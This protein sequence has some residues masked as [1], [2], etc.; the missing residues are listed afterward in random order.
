MLNIIEKKK[1]GMAL[2]KEE[3]EYVVDGATNNTI[4]DYQLS[5]L[6]MAIYFNG[7]DIT[8]TTY[9]TLAMANSGDR[10]DLSFIDGIKVDKHSTG[11][12]GDSTT[13]IVAPLVVACGGIV[14]KM[15]GR[16][17]G[18]TGGTLD[19][20]MSIPN[21]RI[22]FSSDEFEKLVLKNRLAVV[23][24]S[25]NLAPADKTLYALRD[26]TATVDNIS[27]IS[28]SIMSKKIAG[29]CDAL[30][31]DVKYGSGSLV[32]SYENA[33]ELADIMIG[34]GKGADVETRAVLSDM[35][36]PLGRYIGNALEVLEVVETLKG[37]H[38]DSRLLEVC[39]ELGS[40]MLEL[41][42][43]V[44]DTEQGKELMKK[45]IEDGS[46]LQKLKDMIEAQGGDSSV[47][48]NPEKL[49]T[50]KK[51]IDVT[52][53]KAGKITA[54]DTKGIGRSAMLLGAGREKKE[55]VIDSAVGLIMECELGD[56]IK[57]GDVICKMH[58]NDETNEKKAIKL[59]KESIILE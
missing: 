16:G 44:K 52:S 53:D 49:P 2:T 32:G 50:A 19:K 42:G 45:A 41:S 55:D 8:E 9:L 24:Q 13:M 29:G 12:V 43:V 59:F 34:I 47:V 23:G 35:N 28:S 6:M 38:N 4:P 40:N 48:D 30:V 22:Q 18:H 46:G 33:R 20:L 1:L 15:S 39:L 37:Q 57:V 54:M 5:A 26:V 3:I 10:A 56:E 17:L 25:Q 21:M 11:G 58:I 51:I 31:L 36:Q 14:A 7:M 27:L